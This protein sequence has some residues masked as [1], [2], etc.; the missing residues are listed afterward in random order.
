[1]YSFNYLRPDSL[2]AAVAAA[3]VDDGAFLA[4]G[5]TLLPALKMRLS[6]RSG[7]VDLSGIAELKGIRV[8]G[9]R[10]HVGA[11]S[12]HV[13]VEDSA[14]LRKSL[15]ALAQ[16][17]GGIGDPHVRN[18]GTLGGALANS[19]PSAD[20]PAA[21]LALEATIVTD[22]RQIAAADFFKGMFATALVAGELIVQVSFRIPM[23][24]AYVKYRNP[25]S[26]Y[27]VVGVMVAE[28][29][30]GIRVAVTGAGPHAFRLPEFEQALGR[31]FSAEAVRGL[32]V[33]RDGLN[34]DMHATADYRA[35]LVSVIAARA[36]DAARLR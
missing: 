31:S 10:V 3:A 19:D 35:S 23:R 12:R 16:L 4:G 7:L 11:M 34:E 13:E 8:D 33:A 9:D 36:V 25:A 1:M 30:S 20:Y 24:C 32:T 14:V 21:V 29:S 15:P 5:M 6:R 27:A 18:R 17:A 22:R 26:R 2:Q 28:F